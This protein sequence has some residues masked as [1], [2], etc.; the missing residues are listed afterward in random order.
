[1]ANE[2]ERAKIMAEYLAGNTDGLP[3]E[4]EEVDYNEDNS[5]GEHG[6]GEERVS[7]S[8]S[9]S[10]SLNI[11]SFYPFVSSPL[12]NPIPPPPLLFSGTRPTRHSQGGPLQCRR[13]RQEGS[14]LHRHLVLWR[15]LP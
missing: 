10:V 13:R 14:H 1:M 11:N 8:L 3:E 4:E 5:E 2:E 12:T 15:R 9:Q 6:D 7:V